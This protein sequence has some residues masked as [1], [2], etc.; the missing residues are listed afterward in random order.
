M[1]TIIC[2][3]IVWMMTMTVCYGQNS[4]FRDVHAATRAFEI[5]DQQDRVD[6]QKAME[7]GRTLFG[8]DKRWSDQ[9]SEFSGTLFDRRYANDFQIGDWGCVREILEVINKVNSN[10]CL[11]ISIAGRS[12]FLDE[13][14]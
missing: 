2:T 4:F 6:R 10:Q 8:V 1:K 11:V 9:K 12:E 13:T 5:K 7:V 3:T 14:P